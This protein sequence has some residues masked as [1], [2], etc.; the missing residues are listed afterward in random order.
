MS[1]DQN[2]KNLILDYPRAAL[3]FFAREEVETIP[4]TARITPVR[5]EQ[6]K[7]RLGDRFRELDTPLLVEFSREKKQAV[8]FILEEETDTRYFSIHRLIHYCV[9]IADLLNINRVVPVVVFLRPGRHPLSLELGT[10]RNTYLSFRFIAC[11]LGEIPAAQHLTSRNIVARINL[12]NMR[13]EP[14]QRVEICLRAQEGLAQLE[15]DP[16]KRI[17][18]IDFIAQ[19]ARLSEAE[20]ARYEECIEQ[21]SY[22]EK[23]MG[24]V[25]Q[26]IEKSLQQGIQQGMQQGMRQ[27]EHK[28]AVEIAKALLGK[29]MNISDIS[30]ISGLSGKEIRKLLAH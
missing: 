25:Q 7:K 11:D 16:N 30:E 20:Q 13:H 26:A 24:P 23:I 22:K 10:E 5:Q 6:L 28:K 8:L 9:D 2:F 19:Y 14:D 18:Y 21:S 3:E 12:P 29:G 4:P 1:H 17:K 15:P 27:G